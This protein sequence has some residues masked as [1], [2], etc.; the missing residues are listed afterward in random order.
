MA[1]A[2]VRVV[3]VAT[4]YR[5]VA[6]VRAYM[7]EHEVDYPVLLG[8]AAVA[9]SFGVRAFPTAFYLD[10]HGKIARATMGYTTTF[11]LLWRA[12][13]FLDWR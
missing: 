1:G 13:L 12:L 8:N 5:S 10:A 11:G 2:R 9:R 7:S 3:S 4:S 6:E